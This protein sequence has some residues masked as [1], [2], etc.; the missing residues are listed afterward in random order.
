MAKSTRKPHNENAGYRCELKCKLGG[1]I[2]IYD[3]QQGFDCDANYRYVVMHE[4]SSLHVAVSSMPQARSI[5]KGVA[6][7]ETFEEAKQI[8]DILPADVVYVCMNCRHRWAMTAQEAASR[9]AN[10]IGCDRCASQNC[11]RF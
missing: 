2:V 3:R 9:K 8:A 4:P 11:E 10:E 1:H 5:M 7:A 6:N